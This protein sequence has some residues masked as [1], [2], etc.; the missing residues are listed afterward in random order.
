[1][2]ERGGIGCPAK[3]ENLLNIVA[4]F[5]DNTNP[6]TAQLLKKMGKGTDIVT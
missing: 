5:N 2:E 1:M 3:E 6:Q 4:F